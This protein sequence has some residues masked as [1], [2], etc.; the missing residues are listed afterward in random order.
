[1]R[2]RLRRGERRSSRFGGEG[3]GFL[4]ITLQQLIDANTAVIPDPD[5]LQI[6]DVLTIP[7]PVPTSL[8]AASEIPAAS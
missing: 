6:G 3:L 7:I 8:P 5:K 2:Q 1:V 4:G